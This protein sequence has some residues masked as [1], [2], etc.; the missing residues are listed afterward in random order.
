MAVRK[1]IDNMIL[2]GD[3][4]RS[5]VE[6]QRWRTLDIEPKPEEIQ[7]GPS[8][9]DLRLAAESRLLKDNRPTTIHNSEIPLPPHETVL[10]ST[11]ETV[12]I[13]KTYC[14]MLKG[15][16]SIGRMGIMIHTAGWVDAGFSGQLTLEIV[17]TTSERKTLPVGSRVCQLVVMEMIEPAEKGY[18]EL[19]HSKYQGQEGPTPSKAGEDPDL[20]R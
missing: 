13:G 18:G 5:R 8:S 1:G 4:I 20:L 19:E 6:D 17:N 15:R 11:V 3:M 7:Y 10:A 12:S 9:V 2:T 16:S 14:A